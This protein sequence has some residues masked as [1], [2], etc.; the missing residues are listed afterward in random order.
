VHL[1]DERVGDQIPMLGER[2]DIA[3]DADERF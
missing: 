3:V 1:L 2:D